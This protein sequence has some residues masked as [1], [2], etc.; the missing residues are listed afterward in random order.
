[1]HACMHTYIHTCKN[2]PANKV[3]L[4]TKHRKV[5]RE[6]IESIDFDLLQKSDKYDS[7]L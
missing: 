2:W 5:F 1:M 4:I 6:Y 7:A 3:E